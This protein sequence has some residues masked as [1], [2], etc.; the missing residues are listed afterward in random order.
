MN[1][2]QMF[3]DRG[4]SPISEK[5]PRS[6]HNFIRIRSYSSTTLQLQLQL[7]AQDTVLC[8]LSLCITVLSTCGSE[9]QGCP[10]YPNFL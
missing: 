9:K 5:H 1:L 2:A 7:A 4:T 6:M 8:H 10:E 3:P